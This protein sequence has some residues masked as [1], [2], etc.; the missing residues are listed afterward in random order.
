MSNT[1]LRPQA[2][3]TAAARPT[4]LD[5]EG[6]LVAAWDGEESALHELPMILGE[7]VLGRLQGRNQMRLCPAGLQSDPGPHGSVSR[8]R[9]V[10]ERL[11]NLIE[12]ALIHEGHVRWPIGRRGAMTSRAISLPSGRNPRFICGVGRG[13]ERYL[14][15]AC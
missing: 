9:D 10:E 3:T 1:V 15:R 4:A 5:G 6:R 13:Y 8:L 11:L 2:R 14:P 12:V 7:R